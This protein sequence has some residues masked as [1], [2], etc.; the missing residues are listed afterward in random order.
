LHRGDAMPGRTRPEGELLVIFS[1][2]GEN[3]D[4]RI[5]SDGAKAA[6]VAIL[7]IAS[8]DALH[9]GDQLLVQ[10]YDKADP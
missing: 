5:V 8:R 2:D 4:A 3:D 6:K 9:A 7:M 10:S 1:R